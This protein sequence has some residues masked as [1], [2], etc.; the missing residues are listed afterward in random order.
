MDFLVLSTISAGMFGY[1]AGRTQNQKVKA[2]FLVLAILICVV[3][4]YIQQTWI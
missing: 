4:V 1:F 2:V 3:N